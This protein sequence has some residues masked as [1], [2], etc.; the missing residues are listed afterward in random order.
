M[1]KSSYILGQMQWYLTKGNGLKETGM[2]RRYSMKVYISGEENRDIINKA[3]WRTHFI[4]IISINNKLDQ[5][6]GNQ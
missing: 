2:F 6:V 5:T 3:K 1:L 4:G